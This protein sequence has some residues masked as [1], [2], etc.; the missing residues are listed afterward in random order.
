MRAEALRWVRKKRIFYTVL[1]IYLVLSLMWF[2]IDMADGTESLWF[3]W[4]ML[5]TGIGV[6][7]TGIALFGIADCSAPI[8]RS[9]K[10]TDTLNGSAARTRPKRGAPDRTGP[11]NQTR[12]SSGTVTHCLAARR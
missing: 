5:G 10:S 11:N 12:R 2:A 3:Y 9:A 4:P 1:G 6:A 8:G 7:I